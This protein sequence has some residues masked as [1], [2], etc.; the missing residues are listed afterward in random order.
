M[1]KV[2]KKEIE[3]G[4]YKFAVVLN[5]DIVAD[6][7]EAFPD[8]MEFL[9]SQKSTKGESN[10][11]VV[12]AIKNK[13][14]RTLLDSGDMIKDLVKFAFPRMLKLADEFCHTENADKATEILDYIED[15]GVADEFSSAMFDFIC[16]GF[17]PE[18]AE[19]KKPTVKFVMK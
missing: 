11:I 7:F 14:L 9:L 8:L 3:V 2:Y 10:E 4:E 19:K 17:T 15:N 16:S 6:S 18:T 1:M 13:N 5:R 12:N